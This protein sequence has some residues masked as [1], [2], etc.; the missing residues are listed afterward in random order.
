MILYGILS[1][2][3]KDLINDWSTFIVIVVGLGL[4]GLGLLDLPDLASIFFLFCI[5][6]LQDSS[7]RNYWSTRVVEA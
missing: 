5:I 4:P 2:Q 7:A 1:S 3:L 6:E